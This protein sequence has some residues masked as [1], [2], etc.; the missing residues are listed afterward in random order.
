[1]EI[2]KK[3][4]LLDS[5]RT[6]QLTYAES[7]AAAARPSSPATTKATTRRTEASEILEESNFHARTCQN[8]NGEE[9]KSADTQGLKNPVSLEPHS[10]EG[11]KK[12][13]PPR[14][15]CLRETDSRRP[16]GP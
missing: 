5:G 8:T 12:H 16:G 15:R 2:T 4:S 7:G 11:T 9:K 6:E 13:A 10:Q 14:A 3:K 1:M